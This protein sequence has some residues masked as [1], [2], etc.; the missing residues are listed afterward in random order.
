MKSRGKAALAEWLRDQAEIHQQPDLAL[1]AARRALTESVTL[2]NYQALQR[3][4][5]DTW[6][7]LRAEALEITAQGKSAE[8]KSRYLSVRKDVSTSHCSC[9]SGCVVF[10]YR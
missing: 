5:G 10:Q 8:H 7:M 4:S 2:E 3:V 9:G 1:D 6:E